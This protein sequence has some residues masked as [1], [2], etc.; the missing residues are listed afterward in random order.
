VLPQ[1]ASEWLAYRLAAQWHGSWM[2]SFCPCLPRQ[3]L[4]AYFSLLLPFV[5]EPVLHLGLNAMRTF[6]LSLTCEQLDGRSGR[7]NEGVGGGVTGWFRSTQW[8]WGGLLMV[9]LSCW[10]IYLAVRP[11]KSLKDTLADCS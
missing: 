9:C 5:C 1:T 3:M 8:F 2:H 11:R 6:V 7:P 10:F 4:H